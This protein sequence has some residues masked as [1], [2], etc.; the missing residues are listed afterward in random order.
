MTTLHPP[1]TRMHRPSEC[2]QYMD[3][4][5][6]EHTCK[7]VP[8]Q[9]NQENNAPGVAQPNEFTTQTLSSNRASVNVNSINLN[10][11]TAN[12]TPKTP[13]QL[14]NNGSQPGSNFH[15]T[16]SQPSVKL[17]SAKSASVTSHKLT[18][19]NAAKLAQLRNPFNAVPTGQSSPKNVC[20]S[21][22]HGGHHKH[23][24]HKHTSAR[25]GA[26]DRFE[27]GES[28]G[29]PGS[30]HKHHVDFA[31]RAT[32]R[33]AV[34]M[35]NEDEQDN[36]HWSG[37]K[38]FVDGDDDASSDDGERGIRT[39]AGRRTAEE[40]LMLDDCDEACLA[41]DA[42]NYGLAEP[43]K[44]GWS[45]SLD[46]DLQP[47]QRTRSNPLNHPNDPAAALIN[48]SPMCKTCK[49]NESN[50]KPKAADY[51]PTAQQVLRT[52][53]K[54]HVGLLSTENPYPDRMQ[55][56]VFAK[57]AWA[58]ACEATKIYIEV[59]TE[60]ARMVA[61]Y[62][63][64]L[65]GEMKTATKTLVEVVYG[66]EVSSKTSI[67]KHNR[68]IAKTLK[69]NDTF[70]YH[71]E[72]AIDKWILGMRGDVTFSV[73]TYR[74]IYDHHLHELQNFDEAS[75][76]LGILMKIRTCITDDGRIHAKVDP[77]NTR[78]PCS[79]G[80]DTF[81]KAITEYSSRNGHLSDSESDREDGDVVECQWLEIFARERANDSSIAA[82]LA[83][84]LGLHPIHSNEWFRYQFALAG[85]QRESALPLKAA[86]PLALPIDAIEYAERVAAFWKIS[87]V[88]RSWS[89][90]TGLPTALRDDD[91]PSVRIEAISPIPIP[92][93]PG[94]LYAGLPS[95]KEIFSVSI[96]LET[97]ILISWYEMPPSANPTS[98]LAH[99]EA[100][101]FE[102]LRSP[103]PWASRQFKFTWVARH[104]QFP[105]IAKTSS[106]YANAVLFVDA[107]DVAAG[108]ISVVVSSTIDHL[109]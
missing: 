38:P 87:A 28:D 18:A 26:L 1:S 67:Q 94:P 42:S 77:V 90:A 15:S 69:T 27:D 56:L 10:A 68:A 86:V 55:E 80:S 52:V 20:K 17:P 7:K 109:H 76:E 29:E 25:Q 40:H 11:C 31:P 32:I 97:E 43:R 9:E 74:E 99:H 51:E 71:I 66:F 64:H 24:M 88:D 12:V 48:Q 22:G 70:V 3:S 107:S 89:V 84:G 79:L 8:H 93:T 85:Y 78:V 92:D 58:E 59:N 41:S 60:L 16:G 37:V 44:H 73:E 57:Q 98:L 83:V 47:T 46:N 61:S 100:G 103:I 36:L 63:W 21:T 105:R 45:S 30:H 14:H 13:L 65:Q 72:C 96:R 54:I 33:D 53:I 35:S 106:Q 104:P 108:Y 5:L 75:K 62:S 34:D 23:A 95:Q 19:E 39:Y 102:E 49:I 50:G 82:R 91:H 6:T 2:M 81:K 101:L 4:E